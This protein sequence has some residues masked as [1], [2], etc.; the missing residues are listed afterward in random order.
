MEFGWPVWFTSRISSH[1]YSTPPFT[2]T[3]WKESSTPTGKLSI[4]CEISVPQDLL[5]QDGELKWGGWGV[6]LSHI[7]RQRGNW[8]EK[9]T[10]P[11]GPWNVKD[12]A[13]TNRVKFEQ[14]RLIHLEAVPVLIWWWDNRNWKSSSI[15]VIESIHQKMDIGTVDL[16]S[17]KDETNTRNIGKW[18]IWW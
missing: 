12:S 8:V 15:L 10:N 2:S 1:H 18:C 11:C 7:S 9:T 6:K 3:R 4:A 16:Q 17:F 14:I 5:E 13:T